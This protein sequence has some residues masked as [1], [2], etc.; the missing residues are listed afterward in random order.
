VKRRLSTILVADMVGYSRAMREDEDGT[1]ARFR[2]VLDDV[3][4]PAIAD[5][6]G[7]IFKLT[8]DGI[9]AEFDSVVHGVSA[10]LTIQRS[11]GHEAVQFRIGVNSGDVLIDGSDVIGDGVNVAARLEGVAEPGGVCISDAVHE[12][13]RDR[14]NVTFSSGG[15]VEL[16][17]LGRPMRI[18][19]WIS[20]AEEQKDQSPDKLDKGNV[21]AAPISKPSIAVLPFANLSADEEQAV[22]ADGMT[23]EIT[24]GLSRIP[25]FFVIARPSAHVYKNSNLDPARIAQELNVTYLV[26]GSVR[27][28]GARLRV[29]AQLIDASTGTQ[30]WA[31]RYD[32]NVE[33]IFDM[34]DDVTEAVVGAIAPEFL[35]SEVRRAQRKDVSQ[36]DA[37]EC[38]MRGRAHL[39]RMGR[40]DSAL[41]VEFFERAIAVSPDDAFGAGDLSI[42]LLLQAYHHWTDDPAQAMAGMI[43]MADKAVAADPSEP[44]GLVAQTIAN[45]FA[46]RWDSILPSADRAVV[47]SP[48][49]APAIAMR[50]M[51]M[52][53]LGDTQNGLD[54]VQRARR[55]SPRDGMTGFFL[56]GLYWGYFTQG[57]YDQ[58]QIGRASCRERV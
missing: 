26:V 2:S 8:G 24:T 43:T 5:N 51:G 17:N 13:V 42:A 21:V 22:F 31:D 53:I 39:W 46:H 30:L 55:L 45:I 37:W 9:L 14:L 19:H 3:V 20:S 25:W 35:M 57:D 32:G 4:R 49:F 38:V 27:R 18:W 40:E 33:D 41:A 50:G 56:M 6:T 28:A 10:A 16:K 15:S 58:A 23:E 54:E 52:L 36:L 7:R 44:W 34:Q 29:S 48:G 12:L 11:H 1:A 47:V